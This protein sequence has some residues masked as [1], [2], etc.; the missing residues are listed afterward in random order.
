METS[1]VDNNEL[2][3][4]LRRLH[5]GTGK[6]EPVLGAL[7]E[8]NLLVPSGDAALE[9]VSESTPEGTGKPVTVIENERGELALPAFTHEGSLREWGPQGGDYV[10]MAG[11]ELFSLAR[12]KR[13]G[14]VLINPGSPEGLQIG[15]RGIAKLARRR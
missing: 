2:L 4:L 13:L 11:R 14:A 10:V 1:A 8:A 9:A 15:E 7:L 12:S 6:A 5:N 3:N